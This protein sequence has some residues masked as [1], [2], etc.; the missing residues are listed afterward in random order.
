MR[1]TLFV[2]TL[3][4]IE[5]MKAM[6]PRVKREWV[7]EILVLDGNSTDGTVEYA[8]SQGYRVVMQKSKGI[9]N[10]YRWKFS[11]RGHP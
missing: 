5:G 2:P 9:T 1:I 3:N 6:M 10:A 8:R 7:D 4:E 11:S